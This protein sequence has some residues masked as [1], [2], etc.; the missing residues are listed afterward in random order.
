MHVDNSCSKG[1]SKSFDLRLDPCGVNHD[2]GVVA[3]C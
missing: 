2:G 3:Q 1:V